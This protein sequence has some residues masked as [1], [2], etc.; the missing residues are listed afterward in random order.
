MLQSKA[1]IDHYLTI[2]VIFLLFL[3]ARH[4]FLERL[5]CYMDHV[6]G[7]RFELPLSPRSLRQWAGPAPVTNDSGPGA[8]PGRRRT[9]AAA[10]RLT[11]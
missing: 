11:G 3:I 5:E 7:Q 10:N 8:L 9:E 2:I 1:F 6:I 4:H